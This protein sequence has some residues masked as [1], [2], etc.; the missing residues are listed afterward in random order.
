MINCASPK[1]K[2]F[3]LQS[4]CEEGKKIA[5]DWQ[6]IFA[7]VVSDKGLVSRMYKELSKL[8]SKNNNNNN[9]PIGK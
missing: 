6:E 5:T 1:L 3:I 9:N 7:N 8:N 4:P 2:T